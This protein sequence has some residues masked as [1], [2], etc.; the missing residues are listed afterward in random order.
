MLNFLSAGKIYSENFA[1]NEVLNELDGIS[2]IWQMAFDGFP[3]YESRSIADISFIYSKFS[4]ILEKQQGSE[5]KFQIISGYPIS[6]KNS[7]IINKAA[8]IRKKLE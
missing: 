8:I 6:Y 1:I 2:S 5:Y 7:Q 3:Q 4:N